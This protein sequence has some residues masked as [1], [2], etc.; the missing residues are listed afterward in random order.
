MDLLLGDIY[1]YLDLYLY[2]YLH[3]PLLWPNPEVDLLFGSALGSGTGGGSP[4]EPGERAGGRAGPATDQ[5]DPLRAPWN[6]SG[7]SSSPG[8]PVKGPLKTVWV[9]PSSPLTRNSS[10]I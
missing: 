9:N 5:A 7:T 6:C 3:L 10:C 4:G 1:T 2:L 8:L